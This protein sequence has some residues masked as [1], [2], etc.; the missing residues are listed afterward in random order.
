MEVEGVVADTPGDSALFV[1]SSTLIGL[2]FDTCKVVSL[3][4]EGWM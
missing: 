2:T 3:S 1:R 4:E